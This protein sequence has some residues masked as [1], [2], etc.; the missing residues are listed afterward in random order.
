MEGQVS[1]QLFEVL[2]KIPIFAGLSGSELQGIFDICRLKDHA[3]E[4]LIYASGS[5][6][7]DLFILLGGELAVR[8]SAGVEVSRIRPVGLVGEMGV[9]TEEPRSADVVT[10]SSVTGF[11]IAREDLL[12][13]LRD[14]GETSRKVLLNVISILARKL[15]DTNS[16]LEDLKNSAPGLTKEVE[17]LLA[18]NVFLY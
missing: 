4:E 6:S 13:L 7:T 14:N 3:A 1:E 9:I 5:P 10:L 8:T 16:R 15:F 18:D 11:L 12:R 2:E 17:E